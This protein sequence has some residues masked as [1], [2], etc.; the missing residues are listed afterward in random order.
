MSG[1]DANDAHCSHY[2]K[3]WKG[4][5]SGLGEALDEAKD[6][7]KKKKCSDFVGALLYAAFIRGAGAGPGSFEELGAVLALTSAGAVTTHLEQAVATATIHADIPNENRA[8]S[9]YST[10]GLTVYRDFFE[11]STRNQIRVNEEPSVRWDKRSLLEKAQS[12]LHEG[13]HLTISNA[14]DAA[15]GEIISKKPTTGSDD[16][17]RRK[18]SVIIND[19][20]ARYCNGKD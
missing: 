8:E 3:D 16:A 14:S 7:L 9:V 12:L 11:Q 1:R 13:L 20:V 15:L 6:L 5:A 18:G 17:R 2:A 19:A 10:Q 4:P